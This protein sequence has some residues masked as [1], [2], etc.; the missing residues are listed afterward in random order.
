MYS[1]MTFVLKILITASSEKFLTRVQ[2]IRVSRISYN[3][4]LI[5]RKI[6]NVNACLRSISQVRRKNY[7]RLLENNMALGNSFDNYALCTCVSL[8][9]QPCLSLAQIREIRMQLKE[10]THKHI[11]NNCSAVCMFLRISRLWYFSTSRCLHKYYHDGYAFYAN[12][13]KLM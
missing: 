11:A 10:F 7:Q 6:L 8:L 12:N 1:I 13:K 4:V 3:R 2:F 5:R 9:S